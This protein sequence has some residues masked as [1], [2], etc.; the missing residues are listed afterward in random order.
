MTIEEGLFRKTKAD[1][2]KISKYGFK[3]DKFLYKY[4]KNIMNNTFR[5]DIEIDEEG[6]LS[7]SKLKDFGVNAVRGPRYMPLALSKYINKIKR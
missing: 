2:D 7:F 5:V 6:I 3:K 4:S 1:F